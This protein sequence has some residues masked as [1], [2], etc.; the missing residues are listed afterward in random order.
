[1]YYNLYNLL[2]SSND[3]DNFFY[4]K[5]KKE[6]LSKSQTEYK[7]EEKENKYILSILAPELEKEELEI[8]ATENFISIKEL[9]EK[10]KSFFNSVDLSLKLK[11]KININE[12]SAT[13]E[14]GILKLEMSLLN[15]IE[16]KKISIIW[17]NQ[18]TDS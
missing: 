17:Y 7:I 16:K 3:L 8:N 12:I 2:D 11:K 6:T 4:L 18:Y 5:N 13:L 14:K 9:K 1:M 15:S 10:K